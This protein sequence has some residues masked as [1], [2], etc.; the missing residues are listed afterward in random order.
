MMFNASLYVCLPVGVTN[1]LSMKK[2][3]KRGSELV[4]FVVLRACNTI[5]FF[6]FG[7][8]SYGWM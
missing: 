7:L 3:D 4:Y 1:L 6:N 8:N 2:K 5:L